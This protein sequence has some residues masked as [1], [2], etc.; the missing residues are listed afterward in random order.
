M[1]QMPELRKRSFWKIFNSSSQTLASPPSAATHEDAVVIAA[2]VAGMP[3][4]LG[5]KRMVIRVAA[6]G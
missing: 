3:D 2:T 5:G 6:L 1:S 4:S